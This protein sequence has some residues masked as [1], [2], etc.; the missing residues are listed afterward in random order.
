MESLEISARTADEA[1]ELA[2]RELG[3]ARDEV[4]VTV[5]TKGKAG[6]LGLGVEEARVRVTKLSPENERP[7]VIVA[8]EILRELLSLMKVSASIGVKES[9]L[10]GVVEGHSSVT[11]NITGENLGILI[12]RRGQTLSSLQYL[13]YLM[14]SHRMKVRVPLVVDVEDY[15]ERRVEALHRLALHMAEQVSSTGHSMTLEPML[16][17][18]RRI[19]HL[20]LQDYPGVTTESI[21]QGEGRKVAILFQK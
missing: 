8:E 15:R 4:E 19:I 13:V 12:G 3:A 17:S 5:L 14:L 6:F 18:E 20:A 16:P 7:P 11:L 2:L 1:V 9:S 21:G 10:S